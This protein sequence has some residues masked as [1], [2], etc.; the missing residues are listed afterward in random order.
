MMQA[1]AIA[2]ASATD[3]SFDDRP[4]GKVMQL[5]PRLP[6]P[7]QLV[8]KHLCAFLVN[9]V[10]PQFHCEWIADRRSTAVN[11]LLRARQNPETTKM[12]TDNLAI[13]FAPCFFRFVRSLHST[14]ARVSARVS[15]PTGM[16]NTARVRCR[17]PDLHVALANSRAEI[18]VRG[19]VQDWPIL[20]FCGLTGS[21]PR[22]RLRRRFYRR[23]ARLSPT[24]CWSK[25]AMNWWQRQKP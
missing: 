14:S 20:A 23:L 16:F 19:C 15:A 22:C 5:L 1:L 24:R 4:A 10:L 6:T 8:L 11:M 13:V 25:T 3:P 18:S 2:S 7:N 12:T 17:H 21:A 9:M